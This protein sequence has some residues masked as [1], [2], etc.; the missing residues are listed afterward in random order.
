MILVVLQA[1]NTVATR[2]TRPPNRVVPR[3]SGR[4]LPLDTCLQ[5]LRLGQG[6]TKIGDITKAI[7]LPDLQK[8]RAWTFTLGGDNVTNQYPTKAALN[9][10]YE[11]RADGLQYSSLSPFGFNGRYWYGKVTFKF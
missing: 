7:R 4:D 8:V 3:L 9:N 5:Q 1:A 2:A 10:V 11:D 6:Q